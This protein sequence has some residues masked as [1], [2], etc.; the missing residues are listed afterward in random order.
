MTSKWLSDDLIH[1]YN[2]SAPGGDGR[3]LYPCGLVAQSVFNDSYVL[4][5]EQITPECQ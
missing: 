4:Q 2:T 1:T 3:P 5:V